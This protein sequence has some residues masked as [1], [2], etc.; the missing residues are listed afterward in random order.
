M[1]TSWLHSLKSHGSHSSTR[2]SRP[3]QPWPG[4]SPARLVLRYL[5]ALCRRAGLIALLTLF[6]PGAVF[7]QAHADYLYVANLLENTISK[8]SP[9]GQ[10]S[11]F[12][13]GAS[14]PTGLA[15]NT[16]G[17]LFV[18]HLLENTI[19]K[20]TPSGQVSTFDSGASG[21]GLAFNSR[22]DLFVASGGTIYEVTPSG[23]LS[24]FVSGLT[25]S[26]MDQLQGLAFN[27]RGDLFVA[28]D[29]NSFISNT[30][31]TILEVTPSGTVITFAR[32][33]SNPLGLAFNSSGNLFVANS[34]NGT[35]SKVTPSGQVSTFVSGLRGTGLAFNS[36]GDL[37]VGASNGIINEVTPSGTVSTFASGLG[38]LTEGLAFAPAVSAVP[39]PSTLALFSLGLMGLL[40]CGCWRGWHRRSRA[41]RMAVS[42]LM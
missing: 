7:P 31:G 9:S 25:Q 24:T 41:E 34:G 32:G 30:D 16:S 40:G 42:Q 8:V 12:V 2:Q 14:L 21:L 22:G 13:S 18:A 27:S 36:G 35:I 39:E 5:F 29:V 38:L 20:V 28:D 26:S 10:V 11:T 19:S 1:L 15:F 3:S 37:F 33:L 6:A 4:R 17:D 23:Q